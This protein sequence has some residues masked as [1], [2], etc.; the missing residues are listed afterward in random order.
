MSPFNRLSK[1]RRVPHA[2][3]GYPVMVWKI[4]GIDNKAYP[5]IITMAGYAYLFLIPTRNRIKA[6]IRFVAVPDFSF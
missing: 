3:Q 6:L 5:T 4:H 1:A 2:G